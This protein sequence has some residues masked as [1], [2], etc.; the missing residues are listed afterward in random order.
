[1]VKKLGR[2][3]LL[4]L[5]KVYLKNN[6][7]TVEGQYEL[8][9]KLRKNRFMRKIVLWLSKYIG[10][11]QTYYHI[12]KIDVEQK[13]LESLNENESKKIKRGV[14]KDMIYPSLE[15]YSSVLA[16]KLLGAYEIE[17]SEVIEETLQKPYKNV[18]DIG[19]AEGY[20]AVGYALRLPEVKVHAFDINT[21]TLSMCKE[22]AIV[23]RVNNKIE[24]YNKCTPEF[25]ANSDFSEPTLIISDCEG[26]ELELFS[27]EIVKNLKNCDL[28]IEL[29][30]KVHPDIVNILTNVFNKTHNIKLIHGKIRNI[31]EYPELNMFADTEKHLILYELRNKFE[32]YL[33]GGNPGKWLY[34]TS[35]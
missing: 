29:H 13:F 2:A 21:E 5:S 16:A 26:Y 9:W 35:N 32:D 15:S 18:L 10:K 34:V 25:L 31:S 17:L 33:K 24:Y 7:F 1:M 4:L 12:L 8:E 20:Y 28:I 19:C 23:N 22:M 11:Q 6:F 27:S 3:L 14:F 30:E